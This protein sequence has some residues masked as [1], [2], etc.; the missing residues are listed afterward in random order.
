MRQ[1]ENDGEHIWLR[2]SVT[3]TTNG[4]TRTVEIAIPLRPGATA[5]EVEVLLSEADAGM[6]RLARHLDARIASALGTAG[7]T[8]TAPAPAP[9]TTPALAAGPAA[10]QGDSAPA[11]SEQEL[12]ASAPEV[13]RPSAPLTA[14]VPTPAAPAAPAAPPAATPAAVSPVRAPQAEPPA[15]PA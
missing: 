9:A 14:R 12:R 5:D 2:Q 1:G 7:A 6:E 15:R 11:T 13:S 4:Q 8:P 10:H 3:F